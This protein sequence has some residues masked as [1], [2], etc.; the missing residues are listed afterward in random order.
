MGT[1]NISKK[2]TLNILKQR[3]PWIFWNKGYLEYFVQFCVPPRL[4]LHPD[5]SV[6]HHCVLKSSPK[7]PNHRR[8]YVLDW[9][10]TLKSI[11]SSKKVSAAGK[12][13]KNGW[14]RLARTRCYC[15]G[16]GGPHLAFQPG[17]SGWTE[18]CIAH[19]Q[20]NNGHLTSIDD[21]P[22]K[23]SGN[24]STRDKITPQP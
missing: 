23:F 17:G 18:G 6:R 14:K 15:F 4:L 7:N 20:A 16:L 5:H 13:L 1:L 3:V 19:G 24:C 22:Q 21:N 10:L 9:M 11:S 12:Q 8:Q 2:G